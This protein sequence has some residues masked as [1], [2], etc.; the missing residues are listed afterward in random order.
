M[1]NNGSGMD[2]FFLFDMVT[3]DDSPNQK[4]PKR[5]GCLTAVLFVFLLA[6]LALIGHSFF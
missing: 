5:K 1:P 4:P 2:D 6:A 3:D